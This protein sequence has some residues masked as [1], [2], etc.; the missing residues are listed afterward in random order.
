M[1]ERGSAHLSASTCLPE[2]TVPCR[3]LRSDIAYTKPLRD[4][5][6]PFSS[7]EVLVPS[8]LATFGFEQYQSH[9]R[10]GQSLV[11]L[12]FPEPLAG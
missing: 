7:R 12:Q 3:D 10:Q 8:R 4:Q 1:V 2:G 11:S 5:V 9:L 6:F